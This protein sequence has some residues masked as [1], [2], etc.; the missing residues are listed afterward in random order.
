MQD[1]LAKLVSDRLG[2]P[3]LSAIPSRHGAAGYSFSCPGSE[4]LERWQQL[5]G[6]VEESGHWPVILGD[7]KE[8][9]R[10]LG[11]EELPPQQILDEAATQTSEQWLAARGELGREQEGELRAIFD[12]RYGARAAAMWKQMELLKASAPQ[13]S[14][15]GEWPDQ[16]RPMTNF[17][18][19]FERV[20]EGPPKSKVTLGLFPTK[21]G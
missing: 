17:T 11:I 4:A 5:R 9:S 16:P 2:I 19:P 1:D 18:I 7:D 6:L 13:Q 8:V 12:K 15:H 21:H 14:L 3:A 10:I 20:G